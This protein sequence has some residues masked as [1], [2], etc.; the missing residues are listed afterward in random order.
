MDP[1][2]PPG[3]VE[4]SPLVEHDTATESTAL[5]IRCEHALTADLMARHLSTRYL[6]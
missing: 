1:P 4:G 3:S 5:E 6:S 2:E